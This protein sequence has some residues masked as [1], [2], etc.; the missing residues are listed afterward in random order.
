M[1]G[2]KSQINIMLVDDHPENLLALQAVLDS[3]EYNLVTAKSG[4]E[5]L[6]FLLQEDF[7]LILLDVS[8]P[9]LNGFETAAM[10][11]ERPKNRRVPII[12]VTAINKSESDA[13]RGYSIGA[14]DYIVKPFD[15][16]ILRSKVAALMELSYKSSELKKEI[17]SIRKSEQAS[18][19]EEIAKLEKASH[20]RFRNLANAIP[21]IV[22]I[23][24]PDGRIDFFND[25]WFAYTGLTFEES[26]G[27]GWKK[28]VHPEDL[29][30]YLDRWEKTRNEPGFFEIQYR[31]RQADGTYRWHLGR[32]LPDQDQGKPVAWLGTSTDIDEQKKSEVV[33]QQKSVVAE[34]AA[35]LKS[36]F[37]SHV[38]HELRTPLNAIIGYSSLLLD[39]T[40]GPM[41]GRQKFPVEGV[42]RNALELRNLINN[43]LD[44]SRIESGKMPI[45][46]EPVDLRRLLP[47]IVEDVKPLMKGKEVALRWKIQ[48]DLIT[49][50]SDQ[51]KIRHIFL[52]LFTN[53]IK[54]TESG[55]ITLSAG[56]VEG[57]VQF[58]VQDTGIGM[59]SEE[60]P[61]IFDPFKQIGASMARNVIGSGLGLTIVKSSV[62]ALRGRIEVQSEHGVGSTFTV[63]LPENWAAFSGTEPPKDLPQRPD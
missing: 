15:P 4:M 1:A 19:E 27:W 13:A 8:M 59:K 23:A 60:L 55:A 38:S 62:E 48:D 18:K 42:H 22:W 32:A 16:D 57:G 33:L 43:V 50:Q 63:F 30:G 10:I 44:L 26:E 24:G 3:P 36:E 39:E 25:R 6:K 37:V 41:S 9:G 11:R 53:A 29:P 54:F 31:L 28:A 14:I 56:N 46:S 21:Q 12:F 35:R 2:K 49:I 51:S 34:E 61:L 47:E 20:E 52:N 45:F 7:D 58:S 17:E 40:Y 5:A